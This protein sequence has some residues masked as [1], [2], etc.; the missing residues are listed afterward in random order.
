[1]VDLKLDELFGFGSME[2]F[3]HVKKSGLKNLETKFYV[4]SNSLTR[5]CVKYI[6]IISFPLSDLC[7]TKTTCKVMGGFSNGP[8]QKK[9]PNF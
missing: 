9:S 3:M 2:M 6:A 4:N 8:N 5:L 7:K 1:L